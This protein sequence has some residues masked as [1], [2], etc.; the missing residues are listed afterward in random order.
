MKGRGKRKRVRLV[1]L[2]VEQQIVSGL[3]VRSWV[4]ERLFPAL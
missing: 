3:V 1:V 2:R 4:Y